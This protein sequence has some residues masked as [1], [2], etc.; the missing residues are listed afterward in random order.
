MSEQGGPGSESS[1]GVA[2]DSLEDDLVRD[3]VV[4]TRQAAIDGLPLSAALDDLR[5]VL[6]IGQTDD[7]PPAVLRAC[8]LA[9]AG[10]HQDLAAEAAGEVVTR[11]WAEL[12]SHLWSLTGSSDRVAA[13]Q[14]IEVRAATP[15]PAG[16]SD[17]ASVLGPADQ[18]QGAAQVLARFLDLPGEHVSLLRE[19]TDHDPDRLVALVV[20]PYDGSGDDV[21]GE[22]RASLARARLE[23]LSPAGLGGLTIRVLPLGGHP[24]GV[25]AALRE[26]VDR[27]R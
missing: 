15:R 2:P 27:P 16:A 19:P 14:L 13:S 7:L 8:A 1:R 26:A 5:L 23:A 9:W 18:L 11:T 22:A 21:A 25:L 17:L 6:D 4:M 10:T 24:E 12:E 20:P 3:V